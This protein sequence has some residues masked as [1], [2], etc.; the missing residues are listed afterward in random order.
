MAALEVLEASL[1]WT[2]QQVVPIRYVAGRPMYVSANPPPSGLLMTDHVWVQPA[3][4]QEPDPSEVTTVQ[5]FDVN[6]AN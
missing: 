2:S 1:T 4:L 5:P 3:E 6:M